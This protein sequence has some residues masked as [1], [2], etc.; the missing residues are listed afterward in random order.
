MHAINLF[1]RRIRLLQ[2]IV[3]T[4]IIMSTIALANS[5]ENATGNGLQK[6]AKEVNKKLPEKIDSDTILQRA[7]GDNGHLEFHFKLLKVSSNDID[8]NTSKSNL[9]GKV[10][11]TVCNNELAV[12]LK[13][14]IPIHYYYED[15]N[16][17]KAFNFIIHPSD[18]GYGQ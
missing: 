5:T 14:K 8:I 10:I 12:L 7:S 4:I 17:M 13:N 3:F 9:K 16:N 2:L 15:K 11:S 1:L 18:C 6:W